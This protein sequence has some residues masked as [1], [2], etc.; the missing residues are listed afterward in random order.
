MHQ[1]MLDSEG[2]DIELGNASTRP[3]THQD[4]HSQ[5]TVGEHVTPHVK[6]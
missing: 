2:V 1:Y 6:E 5:E 4:N 3:H